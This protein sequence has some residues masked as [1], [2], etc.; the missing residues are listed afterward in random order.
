M[1]EKVVALFEQ[2]E[3]FAFLMRYLFVSV[4]IYAIDMGGYIVFIKCGLNPLMANVLVKIFAALFGF[5][6]HRH[7]TYRLKNSDSLM[8]HAIRYFGLAIIYTPVSTLVLYV[9]FKVIPHLV[10]AKFI[11]DVLLFVVVYYITSKFVFFKEDL[12]SR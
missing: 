4:L 10:I 9:L 7:I 3:K 6:A 8:H 1:I 2:S 11:G 12:L 5:F